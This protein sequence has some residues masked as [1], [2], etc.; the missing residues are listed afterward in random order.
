M[1]DK[2]VQYLDSSIGFIE[3]VG[4]ENAVTEINFLDQK[5]KAG[6]SSNQV[7]DAAA[8][9]VREYLAGDRK[10][11]SVPLDMAGTE[12]QKKVWKALLSV[13]YGKT[14]SYKYIAE[15]VG[16]PKA[17]RAVGA[18]NGRNPVSIIVLCHRIIGSN[19]ALTGYA[20]GIWRIKWL[21]QHEGCL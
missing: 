3:I 18:A 13:G 10:E 20:S 1:D 4:N 7:V 2:F 8:R 15:A 9:Q 16:N 19:G 11:F 12:F 14:V 21:L 6:F 5:R 17:V